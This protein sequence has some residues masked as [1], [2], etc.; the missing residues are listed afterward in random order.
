MVKSEIIKNWLL[1]NKQNKTPAFKRITC[2][3]ALVILLFLNSFSQ[4]NLVPNGS[5]ESYYSCPN[6]D[7]INIITNWFQPN[8]AGNSSDAFNACNNVTNLYLGVPFNFSYQ[9][10]KTGNGYAGICMFFDST[11][12][13]IDKWREYIE[14]GLTDTLKPGKKY[15]VR[16]YTNKGNVSSY[17]VKNIQAVLTNDSLLYSDLN[18]GY[19]GSEVP[20]IEPDSI[21]TDTL[22]WTVIESTY[23]ANGGERFFTIGNFSS[24][25]STVY[26]YTWPFGG[27][28]NT[29]G[30]YLIDDVSIYEQP[31]VSAGNDT[32]I[33]PG[34][35]VQLG[36]T[37]RPDVFY[38]WSPATGLNNPNIANPMATPGISTTYTL[39]ITDTNQ[40]ACT[41]VFTDTVKVLVG[42]AGI[43]ENL[44]CN[45]G[46][47]FP[48]P[49]NNKATY[50]TYLSYT[51]SGSLFIYDLGGKLIF[52]HKIVNGYNKISIDLSDYQN[53]I[54]L[55]KIFVNGE[56][57]DYKKL[58]IAK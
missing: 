40:L 46:I 55:Y 27:S 6:G 45:E 14:V 4:G 39:T 25:A 26:Q 12:S 43:E 22:N 35:S 23:I 20:M 47:L 51:E 50:E 19:I 38:S 36:I 33:P 11:S 42:Y 3:C 21:I 44:F 1:L 13:N 18:F 2:A 30:Y 54:Y 29:L 9:F 56:I 41:S 10:P 15:C 24:G 53:G 49:A 16:F 28:P 8:Q 17:A 52:S 58:V 57:K 34:D 5:F 7:N 48:N 37:G 32:L 31:D